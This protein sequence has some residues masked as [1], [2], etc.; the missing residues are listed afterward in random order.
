MIFTPS[1][2][3]QV[4]VPPILVNGTPIDRTHVY[5]YLGLTIDSDLKWTSHVHSLRNQLYPYLFV[6]RNTRYSLPISTKRSLYFSYIHS[7]LNYLISI[8]GY[9]S[10]SRTNMLQIMQNKAIRSLFWQEY[11]TGVLN[12]EG[13]LRKYGI[14][15]I[16]Q[17]QTIDS[18]TMIFKI[19]HNIV[20]N[21]INLPTFE[22]IHGY[23]TRNRGDFVLPRSRLNLLH[24]SIFAS[25]LAQYNRLPQDVKRETELFNFKKALKAHILRG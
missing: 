18:L 2:Q 24:N 16:R 19:K 6:L 7:H 3:Q 8:W 9:A 20:R 4:N 13:L 11:R 14:P 23:D 5:T 10:P 15:N 1:G 22:S 21:D 12:T 17:L 25:G